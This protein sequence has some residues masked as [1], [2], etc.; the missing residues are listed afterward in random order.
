MTPLRKFR[1]SPW[2]EILLIAAIAAVTY[3]PHL[4]QATIYRDDW[5]YVMDRMIG[6]PGTFQQMF[7]IDRPARGPLF[8]AYY[9][10]F[11]IQP[12]PYHMMSFV[13]RIAAGLTALWLF[14]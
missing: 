6:G 2:A 8:E 9:Q 12:F 1:Q 3:L 5:Y 4:S 11:G 7:S 13:W 14:R 10:L